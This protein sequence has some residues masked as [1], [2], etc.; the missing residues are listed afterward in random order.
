MLIANPPCLLQPLNR[1][2]ILGF[3]HLTSRQF[4]CGFQIKLESVSSR[5]KDLETLKSKLE[6]KKEELK[7]L[8]K[9]VIEDQAQLDQARLAVSRKEAELKSKEAALQDAEASLHTV[10]HKTKS[11]RKSLLLSWVRFSKLI[12]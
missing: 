2:A 11:H 6:T 10:F 1:V 8:E 4:C 9:R 12:Q 3:T 5:E 7:F